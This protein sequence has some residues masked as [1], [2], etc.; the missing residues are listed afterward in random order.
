MYNGVNG[1]LDFSWVPSS[2]TQTDVVDYEWNM[3]SLGWVSTGYGTSP[4][5]RFTA[6]LFGLGVLSDGTHNLQVRAVDGASNRSDPP[7]SFS[8]EVDASAPSGIQPSTPSGQ[9]ATLTP[10]VSW[11]G[12][13]SAWK[14]RVQVIR[15]LGLGVWSGP[16]HNE[17]TTLTSMPLPSGIL[18]WNNE[19]RV[20]VSVTDEAGNI[21]ANGTERDFDTID[22]TEPS[23]TI[24]SHEVVSGSGAMKLRIRGQVM[25][26]IGATNCSVAI[27]YD[28]LLDPWDNITIN[29]A[30]IVAGPV[31]DAFV[32]GGVEADISAGVSGADLVGF[33]IRQVPVQADGTFNVTIPEPGLVP[34]VEFRPGFSANDQ[35]VWTVTAVD[36]GGNPAWPAGG[37]Q[38]GGWRTTT[39]DPYFGLQRRLLCVDQGRGS[40][41]YDVRPGITGGQSTSDLMSTPGRLHNSRFIWWKVTH[42]APGK[43]S[44]LDSNQGAWAVNTLGQTFGFF[45]DSDL[46]YVASRRMALKLD[47]WDWL[48]DPW[49]QGQFDT[50]MGDQIRLDSRW[51]ELAPAFDS[52]EIVMSLIKIGVGVGSQERVSRAAMFGLG[53][54]FDTLNRTITQYG[55]TQSGIS[56]YVGGYRKLQNGDPMGGLVDVGLFIVGLGDDAIRDAILEVISIKVRDAV[57]EIATREGVSQAGELA[58]DLAGAV[59][60]N[61]WKIG[62][63]ALEAGNI[64]F[65]FAD[66]VNYGIQG[67]DHI[68]L[69]DVYA[70]VVE[71]EYAGSAPTVQSNGCFVIALG[72]ALDTEMAFDVRN[73]S[74]NALYNVWFCLDLWEA[75]AMMVSADGT[76]TEVG[77][78]KKESTRTPAVDSELGRR[79]SI[80]WECF[81]GSEWVE[82]G[83]TNQP[84]LMIPNGESRRFR[85]KDVYAISQPGFHAGPYVVQYAAWYNG[86][87]GEPGGRA[88]SASGLLKQ[89][90]E[91]TDSVS[92][93][94]VPHAYALSGSENITVCWEKLPSAT[95]GQ[96]VNQDV[97]GYYVYR[98]TTASGP[99]NSSAILGDGYVDARQGQSAIYAD[100]SLTLGDHRY[101]RVAAVDSGNNIGTLSETVDGIV[102]G[103]PR[104][105]VS[106]GNRFLSVPHGHSNTIDAAFTIQNVGATWFTWSA[107]VV[108]GSATLVPPGGAITNDGIFSVSID[109]STL[110]V[111]TNTVSVEIEATQPGGAPASGSPGVVTVQVV[112]ATGPF[113]SI[114]STYELHSFAGAP[115][116]QTLQGRIVLSNE[117]GSPMTWSASG[118]VVGQGW[119]PSYV[120]D[121]GTLSAAASVDIDYELDVQTDAA[122]ATYYLDTTITGNQ[123]NGGQQHTAEIRVSEQQT[124][125]RGT[126]HWWLEG[127]G[128]T[129]EGYEAED[130]LDRDG[131]GMFAWEEYIAGTSPTNIN[132]NLS[133]LG[134]DLQSGTGGS[135]EAV[136]LDWM[137]V[138]G[139]VYSLKSTDDLRGNW[140]QLLQMPGDGNRM[141]CSNAVPSEGSCFWRLDVRN[142]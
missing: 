20:Y 45:T 2:D 123:G 53:Q 15:H 19:Y 87:P 18:E 46:G 111:G 47:F 124:T 63:I 128:L 126:P 54:G 70:P 43:V 92:P 83:D 27:R 133:I 5:G 6:G 9:Q 16:I 107:T 58:A 118:S 91:V 101:Y 102:L 40:L 78:V 120:P 57:L 37:S 134:L 136:I 94:Q 72:D 4:Q 38:P 17:E 56:L 3:D 21:G 80:T 85:V 31:W 8:F 34:T 65:K 60:R 73:M 74:G 12:A 29:A 138:S 42:N 122:P 23:V 104:L 48:S 117:G 67:G 132:S 39:M 90:L 71:V 131:D 50:Y 75:K 7:R 127:N 79:G 82:Q 1:H 106:P 26:N 113:A 142:P 30:R 22:T 100:N 88:R 103:D 119:A 44:Y 33:G 51:E 125:S 55:L 25:D 64:V 95:S 97:V 13:S 61:L 68:T 137:S 89:P 35:V 36:Q 69:E 32:R 77:G 98:A 99:W 140:G 116:T 14:Y 62:T 52:A 115:G 11:S 28:N 59:I 76:Q 114:A 84:P 141:S 41:S 109:P 93:A 66:I 49:V 10:T 105:V 86:Y 121:S 96:P 24:T 81:D 130:M 129:G 112:R 135:P 110:L 108:A 139:R